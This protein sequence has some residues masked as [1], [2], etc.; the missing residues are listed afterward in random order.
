MTKA[1]TETAPGGHGRDNLPKYRFRMAHDGIKHKSPI[2]DYGPTLTQ[3][4]F[5]DSCDINK[6]ME[7]AKSTGVVAGPP[8]SGGR[9]PFYGDFSSQLDYHESLNAVIEA[10]NQFMTLPAALR[11]RFNNDPGELLKFVSDK[12]N[13]QE[14]IELGLIPAEAVK[15]PENVATPQPEP[16]PLPPEKGEKG[17]G[18]HP[19]T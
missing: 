12:K 13:K 18:P 5:K 14:A 4:H 6:I 10:D 11:K 9:R 8:G 19:A 16:S 1:K 7:R 17:G 2:I 15:K 3:Q